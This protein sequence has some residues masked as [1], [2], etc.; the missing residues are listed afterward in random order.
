MHTVNALRIE[1]SALRLIDHQPWVAF[2]IHS[3]APEMLSNNVLGLAKALGV[4][5]VL[6]TI[7]GAAGPLKDPLFAG[8]PELWPDAPIIDRT[9]TNAWSD[10]AFVA[11]I[12]AT[13]RRKLVM[14]GLWTEVC[15]AQ[16]TISALAAGYEVHIV[17][18]A[19]GGLTPEAHERA[20]QRMIQAGAV[21]LTWFAVTAEWCPDNAAPEYRNLYPI[22]LEHGGGVRWAVEYYMA[23]LPQEA[24]HG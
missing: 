5:T 4:P 24:G 9:N 1:N 20:C 23:N 14:A 15:L 6:S 19:S 2:P 22:V 18:D 11:A 13:G 21:P 7:N 17:T 3:I 10:P 16:T 12:E 8:L